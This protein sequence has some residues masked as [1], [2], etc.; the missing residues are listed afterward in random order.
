MEDPHIY[1]HLKQTTTQFSG[2]MKAQMNL[3]SCSLWIPSHAAMFLRQKAPY[4]DAKAKI[5]Q[6]FTCEYIDYRE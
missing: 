6:R 2:E 3:P 1:R 5:V 4:Q